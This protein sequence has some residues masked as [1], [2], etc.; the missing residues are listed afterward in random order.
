MREIDNNRNSV[1]FKGIPQKPVPE[2][3]VQIPTPAETS[4]EKKEINDLSK[5]PAA[6]LGKSQVA[7]DST[8]ADM[9]FLMKNIDKV[10]KMNNYFD[11]YAD[12]YGY[13]K[14]AQMLDEFIPFK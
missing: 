9:Q 1:N 7:C 13:E 14:A 2:E 4:Q 12:K 3:T 6:F 8:E 11:A 10:E 5:M